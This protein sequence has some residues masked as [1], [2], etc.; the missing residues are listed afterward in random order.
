MSYVSAETFF[1][2]RKAFYRTANYNDD[3]LL[4][5]AARKRLITVYNMKYTLVLIFTTVRPEQTVH[6]IG[7]TLWY[8]FVGREAVVRWQ[9]DRVTWALAPTSSSHLIL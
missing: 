9:P 8:P 6:E 7:G 1:D 2:L 5:M 4:E 3:L